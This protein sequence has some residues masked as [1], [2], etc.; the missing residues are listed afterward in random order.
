MGTPNQIPA[1][2]A[3]A[4]SFLQPATP[5]AFIFPARRNVHAMPAIARMTSVI[6]IGHNP[7]G[8][9]AMPCIPHLSVK[10]PLA[11]RT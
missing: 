3:I 8:H 6:W 5:A 1:R 2:P 11:A 9:P 10:L 4:A 7:G